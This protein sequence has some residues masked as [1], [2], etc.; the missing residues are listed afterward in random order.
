MEYKISTKILPEKML[1]ETK[2]RVAYRQSIRGQSSIK[3]CKAVV[4]IH[5]PMEAIGAT[6]ATTRLSRRPKPDKKLIHL[7]ATAND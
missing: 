1:V 6:M 2:P 4:G 5:N 7:T 3:S